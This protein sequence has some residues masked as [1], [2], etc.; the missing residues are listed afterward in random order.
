MEN[1]YIYEG[2]GKAMAR[3]NNSKYMVNVLAG[4]Y[5]N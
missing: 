5:N 2:R 4:V 1:Q 3:N